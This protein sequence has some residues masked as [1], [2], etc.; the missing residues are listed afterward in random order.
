MYM[1]STCYYSIA[2]D[3]KSPRQ[4]ETDSMYVDARALRMDRCV[5]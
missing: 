5:T 1:Y 3:F 4:P 2:I